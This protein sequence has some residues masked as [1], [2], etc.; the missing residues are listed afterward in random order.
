M[1]EEFD[2]RPYINTLL[3]SWMWLIGASVFMA[4]VA[5]IG[6][7]FIPAKYEATA[8]LLVNDKEDLLQFDPRII[9]EVDIP[10]RDAYPELA[11]SD[12]VLLGLQNR[13]SLSN[14]SFGQLQDVL[15]V[16]PCQDPRL[17]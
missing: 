7:R 4:I 11:K 9:S 15:N 12:A 17:L 13:P 8:I 14:Y 3:H 5:L 16:Q 2:L 10:L 1:D 6:T